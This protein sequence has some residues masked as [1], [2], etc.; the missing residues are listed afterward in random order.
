MDE[1]EVN[2]S[3]SS[4]G[5]GG[6]KMIVVGVVILA[7]IIGA[8]YFTSDVYR[9]R[10]RAAADQYA[11]WTPENIAKDP[12]NYLN[13]CEEEANKALLGLKASEISIAQNRGKLEA[14]QQEAGTKITVGE[15]ALAEL[16]EL[17]TKSTAAN[18]WPAEWQGQKREKDWTKQ[19]IVSLF[20][21]VEA[22]KN[23][24]TKVEA[25]TKNLDAQVSRVQNGRVQAQ[26][27]L[28][29]I[30]TSREV[31]KVQK[32]T[33]ELTTRLVSIKSV[34]Q[35]TIGT[36]NESSAPVSL[37]QLTAQAGTVVDNSEFDKIMG[38]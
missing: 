32:I 13:F 35:A 24:K 30:K 25:A 27:Q 31:L 36:V 28:A 17:Y 34:L 38:K 16:K 2:N 19:Q 7:V 21:Q 8:L 33:D 15:K 26:G 6:M 23:L 4:S 5:G 14:M 12:E 11:H 10:I 20:K 9:T 37:D 22:Q 18:T 1:I 3:G 29:E